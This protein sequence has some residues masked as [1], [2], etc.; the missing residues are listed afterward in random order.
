MLE[1][2]ELLQKPLEKTWRKLQ[3]SERGEESACGGK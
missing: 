1:T 3:K 2:K